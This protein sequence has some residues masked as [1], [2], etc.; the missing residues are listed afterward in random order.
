MRD[1]GEHR[2][3]RTRIANSTDEDPFVTFFHPNGGHHIEL[4]MFQVDAGWFLLR[5][6][7]FTSLVSG[8]VLTHCFRHLERF[9]HSNNSLV[10]LEDT[11]NEEVQAVEYLRALGH[12]PK[13]KEEE[14]EAPR[15]DLSDFRRNGSC[16]LDE[17]KRFCKA[18]MIPHGKLSWTDTDAAT[19][20]R[21]KQ[22]IETYDPANALQQPS[23][24][25]NVFFQAWFLQHRKGAHSV[26][27]AAGTRNEPKILKGLM[28]FL[29]KSTDTEDSVN[30]TVKGGP[31][32]DEDIESSLKIKCHC[33]RTTGI[34]VSHDHESI[35]TSPDGLL[36][37]SLK[38]PCDTLDHL[39]KFPRGA[40]AEEKDA[41]EWG[42]VIVAVEVKTRTV[43]GT[44]EALARKARIPD[45]AD[46]ECIGVGP[47]SVCY[48]RG[49]DPDSDARTYAAHVPHLNDRRQVN[50]CFRLMK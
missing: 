11:E 5:T 48:L 43:F 47:F 39:L 46:P 33:L 14:L 50:Q 1:D 49:V 24:M 7:R 16:T 30:F 35:G 8:N 15:P 26:A 10:D 40:A 41:D 20:R 28:D 36:K 25:P 44:I 23:F 29:N 2:A 21:V 22:L 34:I 9:G 31:N 32:N 38:P 45:R 6:F 18:R 12:F 13:Y 4:T 42:E 37:L 3:K 27:M 19:M 17:I